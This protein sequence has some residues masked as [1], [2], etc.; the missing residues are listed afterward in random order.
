MRSHRRPG[1]RAYWV[2]FWMVMTGIGYVALSI[3]LVAY[4]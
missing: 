2:D 1:D 4:P 3:A